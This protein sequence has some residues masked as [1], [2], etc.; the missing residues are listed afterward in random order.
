MLADDLAVYLSTN[1][2]GGIGST[3]DYSIFVGR[4][5]PDYPDKAI[6]IIE[7]GGLGLVHAFSPS[8]GAAHLERPRAQIL[9]RS[10]AY[11]TGRQKAQDIL[12]LL[13]GLSARTI[14]GVLYH[15]VKAMQSPFT[16]GGDSNRSLGP[17]GNARVLI[18]CNYDVAR[19]LSTA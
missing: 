16:L 11:S 1:N 7:T 17:D 9:V 3:T 5:L 13:D 8:P 18:A 10:P 15:Y 12:R 4:G 14:N 2:V 6:G 19:S